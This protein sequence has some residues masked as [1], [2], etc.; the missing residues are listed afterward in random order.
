MESQALAHARIFTE[1]VCPA[2][3]LREA[4]ARAA[5]V[6]AEWAQLQ[7]QLAGDPLR[8]PPGA[9]FLPVPMPHGVL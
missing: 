9:L 3:V 8:Y 5:A 1:T 2:Q 4:E 7:P 6:D